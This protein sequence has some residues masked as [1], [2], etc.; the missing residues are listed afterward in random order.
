M[1]ESKIL[2]IL[3]DLAI[4]TTHEN[5]S[6]QSFDNDNAR[7]AKVHSE[8][9]NEDKIEKMIQITKEIVK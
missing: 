3:Y 4:N 6:G 5:R 1:L 8:A 7:F 2:Y 9:Y